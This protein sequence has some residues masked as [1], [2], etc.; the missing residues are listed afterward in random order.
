MKNLIVLVTL[1]IINSATHADEWTQLNPETSGNIVQI[2]MLNEISGYMA[3]NE[4][5]HA[6]LLRTSNAGEN[7]ELSSIADFKL[8]CLSIS[9]DGGLYIGGTDLI[10]NCAAIFY[11]TDGGY[12]WLNNSASYFNDFSAIKSITAL[13]DG[14]ASATTNNGQILTTHNYFNTHQSYETPVTNVDKTLFLGNHSAFAVGGN[15]DD[16]SNSFLTFS[17]GTWQVT[18]DFGENSSIRGITINNASDILLSLNSGTFP[19]VQHYILKSEDLGNSW[20]TVAVLPETIGDLH[21]IDFINESLAYTYSE[22][23][24]VYT[25]NDGGTTWNALNSQIP[26][27]D[28]ND[29]FILSNNLGYAVGNY[30]EIVRLGS[31]SLISNLETR[32]A[33]KVWPNPVKDIMHLQSNNDL[34][35][36]YQILNSFGQIISTGSIS[37]SNNLI[38]IEN[39]DAG[40]YFLKF[41]DGSTSKFIK[42]N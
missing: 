38:S 20:D 37:K 15:I 39:Y 35:H 12:S 19:H 2:I 23:G 32:E 17:N 29:V 25:S 18:S 11:S 27:V 24:F 31:P 42:S 36:S 9:I 34:P 8:E 16:M 6:I 5:G 22:L 21:K 28:L 4:N 10:C 40:I 30:G 7:W 26:L 33:M 14:R 13:A 1:L 3:G 41:S